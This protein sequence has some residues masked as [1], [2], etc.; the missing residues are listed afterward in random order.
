MAPKGKGKVKGKISKLK[1]EGEA[2]EKVE[3]SQPSSDLQDRIE[4]FKKE[5]MSKGL[6]DNPDLGLFKKHFNAKH[7][8]HLWELLKRARGKTTM[9]VKTAWKAIQDM[10]AG[11]NQEKLKVLFNKLVLPEGVWQTRMVE[12][13]EKI[14]KKKESSQGKEYLTK[15]QL[16]QQHGWDEAMA[17]IEKGKVI[18]EE[19]SDGDSIYVR[20]KKSTK[21]THSH[22]ASVAITRTLWQWQNTM[23]TARGVLAVLM[24]FWLF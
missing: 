17:L 16:V 9:D 4:A 19:D 14:E 11:K 6:Q 12:M 20:R 8:S 1:L 15:G 21:E 3:G 2:K 18:R 24:V 5:V 23:R 13:V 7:M 22:S 10:K